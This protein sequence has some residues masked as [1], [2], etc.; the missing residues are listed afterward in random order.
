MVPSTVAGCCYY[1]FNMN[2]TMHHK[3]L[4]LSVSFDEYIPKTFLTAFAMEM[5]GSGIFD[6]GGSTVVVQ[7]TGYTILQFTFMSRT[8]K[9]NK[10]CL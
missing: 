3:I 5:D 10:L 1:A 8:D 6:Q 4:A 2:L 9:A 7:A